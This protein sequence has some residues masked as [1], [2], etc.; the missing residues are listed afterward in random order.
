MCA[1]LSRALWPSRRSA[2]LRSGLFV[3]VPGRV[4]R[5]GSWFLGALRLAGLRF[6]SKWRM[7]GFTV[8]WTLAACLIGCALL[9]CIA[10]GV[11]GTPVHWSMGTPC[12]FATDSPLQN[13]AARGYD[14]AL[15]DCRSTCLCVFLECSRY[16]FES[17]Y[18]VRV[19]QYSF[20]FICLFAYAC[21]HASIS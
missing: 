6:L 13:R 19:F 9:P 21:V 16:N 12:G 2:G 15:P 3:A 20:I 14:V 10:C 4:R 1:S 5:P 18:S 8:P 17:F 11:T 7:P